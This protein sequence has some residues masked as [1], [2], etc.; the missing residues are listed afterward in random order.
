MATPSLD[1]VPQDVLFGMALYLEPEDIEAF[2]KSTKKM[3]EICKSERFWQLKTNA[4]FGEVGK[5]DETWKKSYNYLNKMRRQQKSFA[6][7]HGT[8]LNF[9]IEQLMILNNIFP[10]FNKFSELTYLNLNLK[11]FFYKLVSKNVAYGDRIKFQLFLDEYKEKDFLVE[12]MNGLV[13][14]LYST[15]S[16]DEIKTMVKS[17]LSFAHKLPKRFT[18]LFP[19]MIIT[20]PEAEGATGKVYGKPNIIDKNSI[21][22]IIKTFEQYGKLGLL[23]LHFTI[24]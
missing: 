20:Y 13:Y 16:C 11:R 8:K 12:V 19:K 10:D 6:I 9:D 18:Y 3:Q 23:Y 4:D 14:K 17:Q 24:N 21:K 2:C 22:N 5:I 7:M 1:D 15:L